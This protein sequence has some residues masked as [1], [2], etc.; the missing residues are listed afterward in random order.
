MRLNIYVTFRKLSTVDIL[1]AR[2]RSQMQL[3]A[4]FELHKRFLPG[5]ICL[6]IVTVSIKV[7]HFMDL[8]SIL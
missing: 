5:K 7:Q 3:K 6:Q 2:F 8:F 1:V 4:K